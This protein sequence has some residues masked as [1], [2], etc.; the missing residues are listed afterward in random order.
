MITNQGARYNDKL[1][2][3]ALIC[4]IIRSTVAFQPCRTPASS[5]P[6]PSSWTLPVTWVKIRTIRV[7]GAV[8]GS[9]HN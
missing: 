6:A 7:G 8:T 2:A 5:V 1:A 9:N 3:V 4:E